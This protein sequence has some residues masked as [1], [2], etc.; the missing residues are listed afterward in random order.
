MNRYLLLFGL[1]LLFYASFANSEA[2]KNDGNELLNDC[3]MFI[4]FGENN[5]DKMN[6]QT[7][8][9][10]GYCLGLIKGIGDMQV[11][12]AVWFKSQNEIFCVPKGVSIGQ[13]T[14]V[15]IKF[16]KDNPAILH[17]ANTCLIVKALRNAYPC[18]AN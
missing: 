8:G 10:A 18:K 15:V 9:E 1:I 6:S 3:N 7:S 16:L 2:I 4:A 11:I 5:V 17:E 12:Y 14:R 13:L